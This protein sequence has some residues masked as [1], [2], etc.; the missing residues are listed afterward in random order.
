MCP[1]SLSGWYTI[2]MGTDNPQLEAK[3][4]ELNEQLEKARKAYYVDASP[5]MTDAEYDVLEGR[6]RG[7]IQTSPWLANLATALTTVGSDAA[8]KGDRIK[9]IRPMLS[10]EN[11]YK[12]DDVVAWYLGLQEHEK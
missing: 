4:R 7:L 5:I 9:H 6:L 3:V 12:K 8:K 11:Q 2:G 10:I 1:K